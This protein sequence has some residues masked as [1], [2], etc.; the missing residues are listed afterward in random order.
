MDDP[1][2][3]K[4]TRLQLDIKPAFKRFF[5]Q[6]PLWKVL[7][8]VGAVLLWVVAMEQNPIDTAPMVRPV[9]LRGLSTLA[10]NN[11]MLL[12]ESPLRSLMVVNVSRRQN[13]LISSDELTLF[14]DFSQLEE[15]AY[16]DG[17]TFISVPV[18][19]ELNSLTVD[20]GY[21]LSPTTT[22]L[23]A[24]IDRVGQFELPIEI[25]VTEPP[26]ENYSYGD[27]ILSNETIRFTAPVSIGELVERAVV[28][29]EL[30]GV[31]SHLY[32]VNAQVNLL[33]VDGDTITN[34]HINRSFDTVSI[35][36]P[37]ASLSHVPLLE[38]AFIGTEELA[39]FTV[40][41]GFSMDMSS[42][43]VF[44]DAELVASVTHLSL[45]DID[46]TGQGTSFIYS[47]DL[48]RL[49]PPEL[50]LRGSHTVNITVH[51]ETIVPDEPEQVISFEL[52]T[53]QLSVVGLADGHD[54]LLD[55]ITIEILGD[56]VD[57]T[58]IEASLY[59]P[60]DIALGYHVL[61]VAVNLPESL[62]ASPVYVSFYIAVENML[63][64][65]NAS[66]DNGRPPLLISTPSPTEPEGDNDND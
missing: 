65:I 36:I 25:I 53:E 34:P 50:T 40:F 9:E 12:N 64:E 58:L 17:Q 33:S 1:K 35:D 38:P 19:A 29:V 15:L 21:I 45:P 46:I 31:L 8:V 51:I 41:E 11:L 18:Q 52:P 13:T 20:S 57:V 59:L 27:M 37:I 48:S 6:N 3:T 22:H 54:L 2:A 30:G 66:Q 10:Q 39:P 32:L 42:A 16:I 61:P 63:A 44:G 49:L 47:V 24:H 4:K 26:A 14:V 23:N 55:A 28:N 43:A 5:T 56:S 62:L 60:E 7:A